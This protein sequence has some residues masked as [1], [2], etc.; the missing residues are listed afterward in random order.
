VFART[1]GADIGR[2]GCRVPIPWSGSAPP[3]G[4]NDT[5]TATWLPQPG[6]WGGLTVAAQ[7]GAAQSGVDGSM[8]EFYRAAL[9]LRH[10]VDEFGDGPLTWLE[11]LPE[12]L[13]GFARANGIACVVNLSDGNVELPAHQEVLLASQDLDGSSLPADTAA[14]LRLA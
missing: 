10:E 8:L 1:K 2:D 11:G 13:L 12:G 14:W 5:G 3:Y 7:S 4:F 6:D 9:H